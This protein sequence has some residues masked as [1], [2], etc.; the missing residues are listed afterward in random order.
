MG[1]VVCQK[2]SVAELVLYFDVWVQK[3]AN[4]AKSVIFWPILTPFCQKMA[5][6]PNFP[7]FLGHEND[8]CL[9]LFFRI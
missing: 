6:Q 8:E 1:R 9:F 4:M 3:I 7:P 2:L 5:K